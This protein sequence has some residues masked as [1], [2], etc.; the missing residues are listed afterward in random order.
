MAKKRAIGVDAGAKLGPV[1]EDLLPA[2]VK[3]TAYKPKASIAM[4]MSY[5]HYTAVATH[6][7]G[8]A[9]HE[10]FEIEPLYP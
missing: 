4:P 3:P 10:K 8:E 1:D 5:L 9:D 6:C 2:L 7:R